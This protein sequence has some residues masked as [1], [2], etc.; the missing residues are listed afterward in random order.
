M[1]LTGTITGTVA[2]SETGEP[3]SGAQV[4]I[5]AL[6]IGVLASAGGEFEL[7][8][9]PVG[10]HEVQ[11]QLIGHANATASVTV[12][13]GGTAFV[14]LLM[15]PSALLLTGIVVTGTACAESPVGRPYSISVAGRR[16]LA[17]QGAPQAFDFFR[18]VPASQGILGALQGRYSTRPPGLVPETVANVNLRG[19]G[20]S[21][22]LVLLNGRRQVSIPIRLAGG[23][24]VDVNAFPSVALDRVEVVKVA[25]SAVYGPDAVAGV[26]SFL[27]RS[28]FEGFEVSGT[29]EYFSGAGET[30]AGAIWGV[31]RSAGAPTWSSRRKCS[32]RRS[33]FPRRGTGR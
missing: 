7:L 10:T 13:A 17:E 25:A 2:D 4:S 33:W 16:T 18:N 8:E 1:Q 24:F 22:T 31:R 32:L 26:V 5:P 9:V 21:R 3:L 19:I 14:E 15:D 29:H 6:Q 23:R 28:G 27:T 12:A 30:N 20:A 11:A